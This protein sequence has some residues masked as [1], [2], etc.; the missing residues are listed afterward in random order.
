[1]IVSLIAAVAHNG[2][3]GR[4]NQMPWHLPADLK[5]FR[6]LT[7]GKPIIMGRRTFESLGR[8]LLPGRLNIILTRAAAFQVDGAVVAHS[9]E[10]ALAAAEPAPEVMIIGGA[11][12]YRLFY[13]RAQHLYLTEI[14]AAIDGD[15]HFPE[16]ARS[17]WVEIA[18]TH[19]PAD[20]ANPYPMDFVEY[21]RAAMR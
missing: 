10:Q 9:V 20:A 18:R 17:D 11:E 21:Q 7:L 2:V 1:M 4:D 6:A 8:K 16:I 14:D 12:V 13:A 5:H 15:T 19:R 3:L